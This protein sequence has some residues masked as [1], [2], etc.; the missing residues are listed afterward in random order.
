M[1]GEQGLDKK[2][3]GKGHK[4]L[5]DQQAQ[6]LTGGQEQGQVQAAAWAWEPLKETVSERQEGSVSSTGFKGA[7]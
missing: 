1:Q 7:C 3:R 6:K 5:L 4:K 2:T